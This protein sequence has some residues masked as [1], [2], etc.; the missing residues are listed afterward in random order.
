M[1][2][3]CYFRK[4]QESK[5]FKLNPYIGFGLEPEVNPNLFSNCPELES[6]FNRLQL[7][8]YAS[9]L[10]LW[11]NNKV[12]DWVGSTSYRQLDK[13]NHKFTSVSQIENYLKKHDILAWGQYNLCNGR[14][15]SISLKIQADVCHPGLNEFIDLVLSKFNLKIPLGWNSQTSGFFANYWVMKKLLFEDFMNFSWPMVEWS[16]NNIKDT[17]YYKT[18]TVYGTVGPEKCV[19]YFMER[20][21][22]IWY[23][24]KGYQPF[25]PS[26]PQSL[27]HNTF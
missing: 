9:F 15:K 26:T 20:L 12:T 13:F 11:R 4:D 18:Q 16:I 3:Q 22:I 23:L 8:E 25:N 27:F 17:N 2:Y 10:W 21:F 24:S 14:G 19:G 6:P 1:I 7:T 5:I